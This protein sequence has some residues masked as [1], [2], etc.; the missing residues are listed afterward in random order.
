M[1]R[2]DDDDEEA[3]GGR[4][5]SKKSD[6]D[7]RPRGSKDKSSSSGSRVRP[8]VS[9]VL[10]RC[11]DGEGKLWI[12]GRFGRKK[13]FVAVGLVPVEVASYSPTMI[14]VV[15]PGGCFAPGDYLLTVM[16]KN[17][18]YVAFEITFAD[19]GSGGSG[20]TGATGPT[21]ATG[22]TGMDGATGAQ[23]DPGPTGTM[24][25]V[26]PTGTTGTQG[27]TGATGPTGPTGATGATGVAGAQSDTGPQGAL[28]DNGPQGPSGNDGATGVTG[29]AGAQGDTGQQGPR[30]NDG[31]TGAQGDTGPQGA[32]G[33]AGPQG[34][35]GDTGATG[36]AGT[37][38][39]SLVDSIDIQNNNA[40]FVGIGVDPTVDFHV[41]GEVRIDGS[42]VFNEVGLNN[43]VR[44]ESEVD[45]N[46]F[47]LNASLLNR[48]GI[49]TGSPLEGLLHLSNVNDQTPD[50]DIRTRRR[51]P[52]LGHSRE[53][54]PFYLS[55]RVKR[56]RC[57]HD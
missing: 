35:Q 8:V 12:Q 30:G 39:W 41:D 2:D 11:T 32:L 14:D 20:A 56:H 6:S 16:N 19:P 22:A 31:A 45:P 3:G 5:K 10:Q 28:G 57:A 18:Q 38:F 15:I 34:A 54:E 9:V 26:G 37:P 49:G 17:P 40:G 25:D 50:L 23:G 52:T 13:P 1:A 21:G 44:M 55:R 36:P 53:R 51:W 4:G 43:N 48:I 33:D 42:T 47:N 7:V 29:A 24:G 46:M 27:S